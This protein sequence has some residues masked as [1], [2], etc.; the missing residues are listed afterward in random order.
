MFMLVQTIE[1]T[2]NIGTGQLV[3]VREKYDDLY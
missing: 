3:T 1:V 2:M